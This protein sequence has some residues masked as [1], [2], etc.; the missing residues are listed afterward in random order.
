MIDSELLGAFKKAEQHLNAARAEIT[1][2]RNKTFLKTLKR[3]VADVR[4]AYEA[5]RRAEQS[6]RTFPEF[7]AD[8]NLKLVARFARERLSGSYQ[9]KRGR[10]IHKATD[11]S[12]EP[13]ILVPPTERLPIDLGVL[14]LLNP[15]VSEGRR[16]K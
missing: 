11:G 4:E 15:T 14:D 12:A 6:Y 7:L 8:E 9:V 13:S 10:I 3:I 1:A 2:S 16:W 5:L